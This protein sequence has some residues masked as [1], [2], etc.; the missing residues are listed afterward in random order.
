MTDVAGVAGRYNER[1]Y[2]KLTINRKGYGSDLNAVP[3]AG[4]AQVGEKVSIEL[5]VEAV[6]QTDD[7]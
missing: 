7:K 3:S 4:V 6:Q 5:N 2:W 1:N